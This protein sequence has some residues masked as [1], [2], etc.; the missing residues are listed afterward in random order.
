M[1]KYLMSAALAAVAI[2]ATCH[3]ASAITAQSASDVF[4][5]RPYLWLEAESYASL[6]EDPEDNGWLEVSKENPITSVGGLDILPSD[7]NVSGTAI[8]DRIGG[9]QHSDTA[10]YEVQF[11][12]AGTY[13][14]YSRHTMYDSN[15]NGSFSNEDSIFLSPAFNLNSQSDWIGFEG[16][17]FDDQDP[18][19]DIPNP[20]FALDPDGFKP[21]T[22][23]SDNEGWYAIRDWGIKSGGTILGTSTQDP[24]LQNGL[25]HWYNRPAFVS[26]S[27]GV[28]GGFDSDFGFKT[29]YIV[30]QD[31]VG[32]TL[33]FEI[34]TRENYG[35]FDGFLF[36]Q[37]DDVDLLDIYT[38][39]EV[40]AIL[41]SS[42]ETG[43][44]DG[45]GFVGQSD[46]DLAL[47]NWGD[48]SPPAPDGWVQQVPDGLIGQEALDGVLLNWGNGTPP[49]I[50][51]V[52]EPSTAVL[53]LGLMAIGIGRNSRR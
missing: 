7:S 14:F 19:V 31:Q 10:V 15:D 35:V 6:G 42:E 33:T 9:G 17:N 53:L 2:L 46:L 20:G 49:V 32:Q 13:Q 24:S 8:L 27:G 52:P 40:D 1:N 29:E 25:F 34:G 21:D 28:G 51:N 36:I 47:L 12:T 30:T 50:G 16:L 18:E 3:Q 43:D 11:M 26:S 37:D 45:D 38:Q 41:A 39:E 23:D 4:N 44:Y 22:G 5:G 48:N